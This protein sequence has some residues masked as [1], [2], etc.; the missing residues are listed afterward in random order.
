[1]KAE[2]RNDAA[3]RLAEVAEVRVRADSLHTANRLPVP[4]ARR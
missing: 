2:A 3:A 4:S 1:M